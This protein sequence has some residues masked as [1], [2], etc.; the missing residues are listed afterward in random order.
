MIVARYDPYADIYCKWKSISE[1]KLIKKIQ[2]ALPGLSESFI[3]MIL[4]RDSDGT[5]Y[6]FE[7]KDWITYF[8]SLVCELYGGDQN[9]GA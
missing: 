9:V 1:E 7:V 3:E 2:G 4:A 5:F 6:D 8:K